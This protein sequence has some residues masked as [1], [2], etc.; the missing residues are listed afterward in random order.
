MKA[1]LFAAVRG[2]CTRPRSPTEGGELIQ[3]YSVEQLALITDFLTRAR[4]LQQR[5]V[6]RLRAA[7]EV[8][9]A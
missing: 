4:Q 2:S 5:H 9:P 8:E 3:Y 6:E 1:P 7:S